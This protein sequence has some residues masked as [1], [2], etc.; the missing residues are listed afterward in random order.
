[1]LQERL[2][3]AFHKH[4]EGAY[5]SLKRCLQLAKSAKS[6][7][8][9]KT[10]LISKPLMRYINRYSCLASAAGIPVIIWRG[11]MGSAHMGSTRNALF[12]PCQCFAPEGR[13]TY[14]DISDAP[15]GQKT[16]TGQK[17]HFLP[18]PLCRPHFLHRSGAPS[19][20]FNAREWT[21]RNHI[22]RRQSIDGQLS[23]PRG[24]VRSV[25]MFFAPQC[26][27]WRLRRGATLRGLASTY[28]LLECL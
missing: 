28:K 16:D 27:L 18:T 9:T 3:G 23:R 4:L 19:A 1:M 8:R 24:I 5:R 20:I 6:F 21:G 13:P 10:S 17:G 2:I 22:E 15:W 25:K 12:A 26:R 14:F 11:A 7:I